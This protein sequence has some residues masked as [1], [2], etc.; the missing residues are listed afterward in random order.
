MVRPLAIVYALTFLIG[1]A[2]ALPSGIDAAVS[3][4]GEIVQ[5]R[6]T[7]SN[8]CKTKYKHKKAAQNVREKAHCN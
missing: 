2:T 8:A 1:P 7:K 4:R 6:L 5:V 3:T